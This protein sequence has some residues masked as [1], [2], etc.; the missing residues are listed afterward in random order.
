MD[1]VRPSHYLL[2][3][4]H[5]LIREGMMQA[6]RSL[7]PA[8]RFSQ[9]NSLQAALGKLEENADD[10]IEVVLLDLGLPEAA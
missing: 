7:D 5:S 3:D 4:D 6:I 9:A 2:V 10:P 1:P 8:A